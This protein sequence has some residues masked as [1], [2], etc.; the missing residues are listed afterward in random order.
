MS[1]G[2]KCFDQMTYVF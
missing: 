2:L 1:T